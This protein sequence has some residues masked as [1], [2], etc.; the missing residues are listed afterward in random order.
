MFVCE[1][2]EEYFY[3]YTTKDTFTENISFN[4]NYTT[5]LAKFEHFFGSYI[6][7]ELFTKKILS[8]RIVRSILKDIIDASTCAS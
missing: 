6:C 5:N 4:Q 7:P 8:K 2:Q 3:V 1:K